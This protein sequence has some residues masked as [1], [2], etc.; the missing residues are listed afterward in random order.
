VCVAANVALVVIWAG[1]WKGFSLINGRVR[2]SASFEAFNASA[3][4]ARAAQ[5]A[6]QLDP[7]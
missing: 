3:D 4:V 2:V 6:E 1:L 5:L 7:A